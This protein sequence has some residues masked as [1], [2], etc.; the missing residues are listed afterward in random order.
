MPLSQKEFSYSFFPLGTPHLSSTSSER[1]LFRRR[2]TFRSAFFPL[3]KL[4]KVLSSSLSLWMRHHPLF[5]FPTVHPGS[6][7]QISGCVAAS[8]SLH[9]RAFI[10]THP[11]YAANLLSPPPEQC[12]V[13]SLPR[14]DAAIPILTRQWPRNRRLMRTAQP[15]NLFIFFFFFFS[16]PPPLSSHFRAEV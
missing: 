4:L 15:L 8:Y 9:P 1:I 10:T 2:Q 11:V 5:S 12:L 13:P 3:P 16:P 6:E 14:I 7:P